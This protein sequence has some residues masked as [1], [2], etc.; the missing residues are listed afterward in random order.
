MYSFLLLSFLIFF[1]FSVLLAFLFFS[2]FVFS[3]F[4]FS[5]LLSFFSFLTVYV[6]IKMVKTEKNT[7]ASSN[8]A[9]LGDNIQDIVKEL[10]HTLVDKSSKIEWLLERLEFYKDHSVLVFSSW[11]YSNCSSFFY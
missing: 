10:D 1:F 3:F 9:V 7:R 6:V 2:S 4:L 11:Y 5:S 8:A